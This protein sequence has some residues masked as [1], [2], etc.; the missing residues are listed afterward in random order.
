MNG[1]ATSTLGLFSKA[2]FAHLHLLTNHIPVFVLFSGLV[3]AAL[4]AFTKSD[5]AKRIA[6]CLILLGTLGGVMTLWFGQQAYGSIR[7]VA[8][9]PGQAWLDLHMERAEGLTWL[10]WMS[11]IVAGGALAAS[12]KEIVW[13]K[14]LNLLSFILSVCVWGGSLWIAEAGGKIRHQEIRDSAPLAP[15]EQPHLH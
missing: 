13:F 3:A 7:A 1:L 5:A 10:Y 4:A 2:E 11:S 9:E 12:F 8:D 14:T 15:H 6:L